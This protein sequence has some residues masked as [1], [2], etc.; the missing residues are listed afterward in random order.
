MTIEFKKARLI[1]EESYPG[2]LGSSCIVPKISFDN[3]YN[4]MSLDSTATALRVSGTATGGTIKDTSGGFK[5]LDI[6]FGFTPYA[7]PEISG[8]R[9]AADATYGLDPGTYYFAVSC[10]N[11]DTPGND[12]SYTANNYYSGPET[13]PISK[14]KQV[15]ISSK[16]KVHLYIN[17]PDLT[18]GLCIYYGVSSGATVNLKLYHVTNLVHKLGTTLTVGET[19]SIILPTSHPYPLPANG[20]VKIDNEYIDYTTCTWSSDHYILGTLSRGARGTT[21]AEH[22][23]GSPIYLSMYT[24]GV[25]G[26]LPSKIYFRPTVDVN[27]TQW[28]NFDAEDIDDLSNNTTPTAVGT[29]E[30][31]SLSAILQSSLRFTGAG[32]IDSDVTLDATNGTV[33]FYLAFSDFNSAEAETVDPYIF[34]TAAGLWMKLSRFNLKPYFGYGDITILS[35]NDPR[36]PSLIR[37]Q[38]SRIGLSWEVDGSYMK[39]YFTV[40]G[41]NIFSE[42]T[43]VESASF[44]PGEPN[45]GGLITGGVTVSNTFSGYLDDWRVYDVTYTL[46]GINDFADIHEEVTSIQNY[47][48]GLVTISTDFPDYSG[49]NSDIGTGYEPLIDTLFST[50]NTTTGGHAFGIY[51]DDWLVERLESGGSIPTGQ[52]ITYPIDSETIQVKFDLVGEPD[53]FE[54]PIVKNIAVIISEDSIS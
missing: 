11:Y 37:E 53:G 35:Y 40:D 44:T 27:C 46:G 45:I 32:A 26:E 51:Y 36:I 16:S 7:I 17:Y 31:S 34:G 23:S 50:V 52:R 4:W 13:V 10:L 47:Y 14:L 15:V 54:T 2:S 28:L 21:A 38:F 6:S 24:G 18:R 12:D 30:Y 5:E 48:T 22:L 20:T 49:A 3:G 1:W 43:N 25:Y 9:L 42:T 33:H 19:S 8:Y 41:Y 29:L 39:F